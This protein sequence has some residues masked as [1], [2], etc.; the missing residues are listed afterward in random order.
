MPVNPRQTNFSILQVSPDNKTREFEGKIQWLKDKPY[1]KISATTP[2]GE[3]YSGLIEKSFKKSQ[4]N[5]T[6]KH[7]N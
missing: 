2:W 1:G 7:N 4:G 6:P 5:F 3:N